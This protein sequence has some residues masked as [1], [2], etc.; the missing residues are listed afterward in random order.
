MLTYLTV[1]A[2][3]K[4]KGAVCDVIE[5][6]QAEIIKGLSIECLVVVR[7]VQT[8]QGGPQQAVADVGF[9]K[10]HSRQHGLRAQVEEDIQ[11][12]RAG[13]IMWECLGAFHVL[14]MAVPKLTQTQAAFLLARMMQV[15]VIV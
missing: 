12:L 2:A 14:Q 15:N 3:T 9:P 1:E 8:T 10:C 13:Q 4:T 11:A 5:V 6:G 7:A